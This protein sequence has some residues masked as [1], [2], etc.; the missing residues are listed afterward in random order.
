MLRLLA[1]L[2]VAVTGVWALAYTRAD[3]APKP[4]PDSEYVRKMIPTKIAG[5]YKCGEL[6]ELRVRDRMA[7][8]VKPTG[9]VDPQ[10]RW[11]WVFPFWLHIN[12]G[13]GRLHHRFYVERLLDA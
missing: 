12:D 1:A 8:L 3:E 5:S 6:I 11:V 13:H 7:Y 10:K 9:K 2:V 4:E